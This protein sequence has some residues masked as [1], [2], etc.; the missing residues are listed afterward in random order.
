MTLTPDRCGYSAAQILMHWLML[1]IIA[2]AY[3]L[4]ELKSS[5]PRGSDLRTNMIAM[6]YLLGLCVLTLAWVRLALRMKVTAPSIV[7]TPAAWEIALAKTVHGLLYVLMV[8]LPLLGW[9]ALSA[10]GRPVHLFVFDLPFPIAPDDGLARKL[11]QWH[12]WLANAGYF[13]IA[14]HAGAAL[15]HHYLRRDTTLKRMLPQ[16]WR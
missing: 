6:H 15:F 11:K 2:A 7:P 5:A 8:G 4:M 12:E 14:L 9:M 3:A 13:V 10:K 1:I 16:A